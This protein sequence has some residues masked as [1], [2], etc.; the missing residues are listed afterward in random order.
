VQFKRGSH[1]ALI[2]LPK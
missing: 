2:T 1:C